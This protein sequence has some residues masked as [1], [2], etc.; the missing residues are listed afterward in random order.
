VRYAN[1]LLVTACIIGVA[2]VVAQTLDG[3]IEHL[4][5]SSPLFRTAMYDKN[6]ALPLLK[7]TRNIKN[8]NISKAEQRK[9][10]VK[11]LPD[12]IRLAD[13]CSFTPGFKERL[14]QVLAARIKE[15]M[16]R[17][18]LSGGYIGDNEDIADKLISLL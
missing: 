11:L 13:R 1:M 9:I 5:H 14:R 12:W 6:V 4:L 3:E 16:Q 7:L 18:Q 17:W 15:V 8:A 10:T 2:P